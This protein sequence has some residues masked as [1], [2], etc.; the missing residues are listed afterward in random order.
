M[1]KYTNQEYARKDVTGCC[2]DSKSG[3]IVTE[4]IMRERAS[5]NLRARARVSARVSMRLNSLVRAR[6]Q[7]F[8]SA[9]QRRR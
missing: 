8:Q 4:M 6:A 2:T 5:V 3:G 9:W 1:M 7:G